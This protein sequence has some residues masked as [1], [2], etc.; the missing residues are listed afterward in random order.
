ML[1][2]IK[3]IRQDLDMA[4]WATTEGSV[5]PTLE[6]TMAAAVKL[7]KYLG[8]AHGESLVLEQ[9][10]VDQLTKEKAKFEADARAFNARVTKATD[11]WIKHLEGDQ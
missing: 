9:R 7:G 6:D 11:D 8:K 2:H 5:A 4:M 1:D 10:L 3:Q